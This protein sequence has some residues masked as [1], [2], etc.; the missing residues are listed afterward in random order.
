MPPTKRQAAPGLKPR[1]ES[2]SK[3]GSMSKKSALVGLMD[4][5]FVSAINF[6]TIVVLARYLPLAEFGAFMIVQTVLTLLTGLQNSAVTQPHNI[7]GPQ[8]AGKEYTQLTA[9][10]GTMQFALSAFIA[11]IVAVLGSAL[12]I[13]RIDYAYL[14]FALAASVIPWMTQEFLRRVL[15]TQSDTVGAALNDFVSYGLQLTGIVLIVALDR[16]SAVNAILMLGLSSLIA[17]MIGLWQLREQLALRVLRSLPE[18]RSLKSFVATAH[19]TWRLSRWLMAQQ[20]VTW[21]GSSSHGFILASF[22]GPASFG[23]YRAAYQVVNVL[24]PIRQAV[25]NHLPSRAARVFA[26]QGERGL[27]AWTKRVTLLLAL[28]F[29]C[30]AVVIA[31]FAEPI[32]KLMYGSN[33]MTLPNAMQDVHVIVAL[34]ALAYT[35]NFARTPLDFSLLVNGQGRALFLRSLW[36]MGFVLTAGVLLIWQWGVRGAMIS[37]VA[38]AIL[39]GTLTVRMAKLHTHKGDGKTSSISESGNANVGTVQRANAAPLAAGGVSA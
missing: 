31:L 39:A 14:A 19:E 20:V 30:G 38:T 10:L 4:Q 28:P 37:E 12:V 16:T 29:A 35:L 8:R 17:A 33:G 18:Y 11:V 34:G 21:F 5:G 27:F 32:A 36:L 9:V 24:N 13:A 15:Y 23:L 6:L 25:T 2:I 7:L 3:T 22:L 26:A 1:T